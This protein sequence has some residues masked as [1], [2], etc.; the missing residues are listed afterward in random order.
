MTLSLDLVLLVETECPRNH[1]KEWT[2]TPIYRSWG[3]CCSVAKFCDQAELCDKVHFKK[4]SLGVSEGSK[5]RK[6]QSLKVWEAGTREGRV[7]E[8]GKHSEALQE[9]TK[10]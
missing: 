9:E 3:S 8:R 4:P 10:I 7:L 2:Q 1:S 6:L 5:A